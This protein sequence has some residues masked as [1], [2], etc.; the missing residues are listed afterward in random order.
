MDRF[1]NTLKNSDIVAEEK[2]IK[3]RAQQGS[4]DHDYIGEKE[5]QEWC[6]RCRHLP[7]STS[8]HFQASHF[9]I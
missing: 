5:W 6:N 3:I 1:T 9:A 7:F 2:A 8:S 4:L